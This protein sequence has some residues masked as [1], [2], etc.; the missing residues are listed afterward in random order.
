MWELTSIFS[1]I[2]V[3]IFLSYV[4]VNLDVKHW[5]I[6][7]FL[8]FATMA[9]LIIGVN[10]SLLLTQQFA[11]GSNLLPLVVVMHNV[12][13]WFLYILTA[14][15]IITLMLSI[16]EL[17]TNAQKQVSQTPWRNV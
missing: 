2:G 15:F 12:L 3:V 9:F 7:T 16:F 13:I 8:L 14:Y 4:T 17:Y 5:I 6:K 1:I 10:L 11:G